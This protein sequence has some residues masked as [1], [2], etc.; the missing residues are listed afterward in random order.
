VPFGGWYVETGISA[1]N[2]ADMLPQL[3]TRLGPD[4]SQ[5]WTDWR[6]VA[7]VTLNQAVL[8]SFARD[9]IRIGHHHTGAERL[10]DHRARD[11]RA[12]RAWQETVDWSWVNLP[13]A[14]PTPTFHRCYRHQPD[15]PLPRLVRFRSPA[16]LPGPAAHRYLPTPRRWT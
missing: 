7:T 16:A 3:A 13:S 12:G 15:L 2:L 14:T 9:G 5:I 8:W 6:N 11:G 4:P 1:R 10:L